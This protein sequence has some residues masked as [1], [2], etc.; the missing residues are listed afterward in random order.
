MYKPY[1]KYLVL[2]YGIDHPGEMDFLLSI[3]EPDIV[4]ISPIEPNH[5]EQFGSY[6]SYR[7]EKLKILRTS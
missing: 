4:V 1:P 2:E 3:A 7:A 5:I 6:E